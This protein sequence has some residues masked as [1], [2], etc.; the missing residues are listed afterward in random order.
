M[1][2]MPLCGESRFANPVGDE[3]VQA[4]NGQKRSVAAYAASPSVHI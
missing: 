1:N 4:I 2:E 3:T